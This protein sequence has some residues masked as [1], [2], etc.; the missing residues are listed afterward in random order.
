[1]KMTTLR[2]IVLC[3]FMQL[4]DPFLRTGVY[5]AAKNWIV[6]YDSVLRSR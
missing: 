5:T 4:E 6:G 2:N 1:M 3:S